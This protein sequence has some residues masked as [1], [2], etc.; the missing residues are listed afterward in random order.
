[1]QQE[2]V[3][4]VRD[5]L[6]V[7]APNINLNTCSEDD[8]MRLPRLN[9][10]ARK[11]ILKA[12]QLY[13]RGFECWQWVEKVDGVGKVGM[14]DLMTFCLDL[15]ST[16]LPDVPLPDDDLQPEPRVGKVHRRQVLRFLLWSSTP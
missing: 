9:E 2:S 8:L 6:G 16:L 4:K 11:N 13:N 15:A 12:R 3:A 14:D 1:M 5:T 10:R 7:T